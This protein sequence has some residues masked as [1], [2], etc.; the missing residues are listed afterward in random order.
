[1]KKLLITSALAGSLLV[2]ASASA[3][4]KV[5]GYLETT[6]G[7]G[8]TPATTSVTNQGTS[9][10]YETGVTFSGTKD[11]DNGM[12]MT[13]K[14]T[15]EDNAF[16]GQAM[17][18]SS[19]GNTIFIGNDYHGLDDKQTVPTVAN[20][21]EDGNKGLKVSYNN[22]AGTIHS[23]SGVGVMNKS[24]MGTIALYYVPK[25]GAS[26]A[27]GDSNPSAQAKSGSGIAIG[28]QG[29]L[30]VEGL[31]V[32]LSRTNKDTDGLDASEIT[33]TNFGAKYNYG[34]LAVGAQRSTIDDLRS[35]WFDYLNQ[36]ESLPCNVIHFTVFGDEL[37]PV[38][39][40][41]DKSYLEYLANDSGYNFLYPIPTFEFG[42][43]QKESVKSMEI[44]FQNSG[45][46]DYKLACFERDKIQLDFTSP[47]F[48]ICGHPTHI[49][50]MKWGEEVNRAIRSL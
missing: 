28:F 42:L 38:K 35:Q 20:M 22:N 37:P 49:G 5:K 29:S 13:T 18:F 6:L 26:V 34:S 7:S 40:K 10:G 33:M 50:H 36:I 17:A 31:G 15:L 27:G 45:V 4:M 43:L 8:E 2:S 11:L 16:L 48:Q 44:L 24:D 3:E 19:D 1:M 9:I 46:E 39:N 21:I 30:G 32:N 25:V 41:I 12:S 23:K 47:N 14:A